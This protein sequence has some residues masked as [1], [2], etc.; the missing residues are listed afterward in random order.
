MILDQHEQTR[1]FKI[2]VQCLA[3]PDKLGT[4]EKIRMIRESGCMKL[5]GPCL[6]L[7]HRVLL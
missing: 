3:M 4:F 2:V 5:K 1:S 7:L 6:V